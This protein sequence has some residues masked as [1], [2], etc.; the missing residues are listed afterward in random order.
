M[1]KVSFLAILFFTTVTLLG[2]D[3]FNFTT[4][5]L[6]TDSITTTTITSDTYEGP[7]FIGLDANSTL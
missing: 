6:F 7:Y 5:T 1:K 4:S 2:C 3:F